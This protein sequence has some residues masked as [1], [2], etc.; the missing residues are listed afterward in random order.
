MNF[1]K[2]VNNLLSLLSL[3]SFNELYWKETS[4]LVFPANIA[5]ILRTAFL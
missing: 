2:K 1:T 3:L 5:K 4:T